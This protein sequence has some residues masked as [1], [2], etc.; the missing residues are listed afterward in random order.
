MPDTKLR[1][2]IEADNSGMLRVTQQ[3]GD[4]LAGVGR[5]AEEAGRSASLS[6][7]NS[8]RK[9]GNEAVS[10]GNVLT[11][12]LTLPIVGAGTAM[13]KTASS[14]DTEMTKIETLVGVSRDQV[15]EWR[16][17]ILEIGQATA[18]GPKELA[19][20]LFVVTSAGERGA[21]ALNIVE[22][23]AKA[24]AIGLGDTATTARAVTSAMMA[25]GSETLSAERATNIMIA[26]VREGNLEASSLAG[27]LGRVIGIAATV[28]V[29]FEELGAFVA[30]FTRLGVD[31]EEAT[32]ALRGIL[33]TLVSPSSEAADA[34]AQAGLS[35][36]ELRRQVKEE[37]LYETLQTLTDAFKGNEEGLS[38]VIPNVRALAG[39]LGTAGVQGDAYKQIV[40]SINAENDLMNEGMKRV[41]EDAGFKMEQLWTEL[42]ITLVDFG[43]ILLPVVSKVADSI[44]PMIEWF[45]KL[46]DSTQRAILIIGG[47]AAVPGPALFALGSLSRSIASLITLS[48]T[49]TGA[50]SGL[51]KAI[52]ALKIAAVSVGVFWAAWEIVELLDHLDAFG[53]TASRVT[54][55]LR[56]QAVELK[57]TA[58]KLGIFESMT[59][60]AKDALDK[61]Y[62][63]QKA[64]NAI[65]NTFKEMRPGETVA[66][67]RDRMQE[68]I[69]SHTQLS[70][71]GEEWLNEVE[72]GISLIKENAEATRKYNEQITEAKQKIIDALAPADS[73]TRKIKEQ[74]D[75]GFSKS[76]LVKLYA[77]EI[78]SAAQ[79]QYELGGK[80]SDTSI[81]LYTMAQRIQQIKDKNFDADIHDVTTALFAELGGLVEVNTALW[82]FKTLVDDQPLKPLALDLDYTNVQLDLSSFYLKSKLPES[83]N[84]AQLAAKQ[85]GDSFRNAFD[86]LVQGLTDNILAWEGWGETLKNFV[87]SLAQSLLDSFL[88]GLLSP[89]QNALANIGSG[90]GNWFFNAI[91]LGGGGGGGR[92]GLISGGLGTAG[93]LGGIFGSGTGTGL[94]L[95]G[96]GSAMGSAGN[97][98]LGLATN[99]WTIG[100]AGAL[101]AAWAGVNIARGP[102]SYEA[103]SEEVARDFGGVQMS[104]DDIRALFNALGISEKDA[105]DVRKDILSS[106]VGL[107]WIYMFAEQQGRTQ[108]FMESLRNVQTS[109]GNLDLS[110]AFSSGMQTG[111]WT[112]LNSMFEQHFAGH[113]LETAIQDWRSRVFLGNYTPQTS[114]PTWAQDYWRARIT[115]GDNP[116]GTQAIV[117]FIM[118]QINPNTGTYFTREEAE[119]YVAAANNPVYSY[120]GT[121]PSDIPPYTGTPTVYPTMFPSDKPPKD[122]KDPYAK[123]GQFVS[124][125]EGT[126][127]IQILGN[128]DGMI[129]DQLI[130]A[131]ELN[132]NQ[133]RV[134]L[135]KVL[136]KGYAGA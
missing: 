20:A 70:G 8:M 89:L 92:G 31:A 66:D 122:S 75:L 19:E 16:K 119:A 115:G 43:N 126:I 131:L 28:G 95:G 127:T 67:Y 18:V 111:D 9:F 113:G 116:Y 83:M 82:N 85:L 17:S 12:G 63:S 60:E 103:A 48:N 3:S 39:V 42:K 55:E 65:L 118:T 33:T 47:L 37:G 7:A 109:W 135:R 97:F 22:S 49:A 106:P 96:L 29:S 112:T 13:I 73:L 74:M 40:E 105:W 2:I 91:G 124:F 133:S 36:E 23:A 104:D 125:T 79:A 44:R 123:M 114:M 69:E 80:L 30:T 68:L 99:P 81:E 78:I 98:L 71:V 72:H 134:K 58:D 35:L 24:S 107:S 38:K 57:E 121:L 59:L 61:G 51:S 5:K 41:A 15:D 10:A 76:Q 64:Y 45:G 88:G 120:P 129:I 87:K 136:E 56:S 77:N 86:G 25:Y 54:G 132:Q 14:F 101:A 50:I 102:N 84:A 53:R 110:G 1:F 4:A 100:I 62:I 26:T 90:I 34:L 93:G 21:N 6:F 128:P 94:G 52:T 46:S 117:D 130:R 27:T 11:V 108:Q 32:T